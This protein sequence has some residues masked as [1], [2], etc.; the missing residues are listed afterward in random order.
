MPDFITLSCPSCGGKLEITSDIERFACAHCGTEHL[1]K[2]TSSIVSLAP[3]VEEIRQVTEGVARTASELAI[4]RLDNEIVQLE[5][6]ADRLRSALKT[7]TFLTG[8]KFNYIDWAP[9]GLLYGLGFITFFLFGVKLMSDG[10]G[11]VGLP[12]M[13]LGFGCVIVANIHYGKF[14][15]SRLDVQQQLEKERVEKALEAIQANLISKT[16]EVTRHRETVSGT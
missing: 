5:R 16:E 1:V 9:L 4:I 2:R 8:V 7:Q 3:V 15:S 12:L 11:A 14:K 6:E 13:L 10:M